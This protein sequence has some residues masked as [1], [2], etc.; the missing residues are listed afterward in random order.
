M[1][2]NC[3]DLSLS[4]KDSL[5]FVYTLSIGIL[6]HT[7][8]HTTMKNR[9]YIGEGYNGGLTTLE[10]CVILGTII[11]IIIEVIQWIN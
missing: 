9:W 11:Y 1:Y 3:N 10:A 4:I 7:D 2:S 8:S 5:V 6:S